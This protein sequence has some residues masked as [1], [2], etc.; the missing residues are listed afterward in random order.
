VT[1]IFPASRRSWQC[2]S[3]QSIV[4]GGLAFGTLDLLF[5]CTFWGALRDVA[6]DRILQSI[7]AGVQGKAAF[8]GGAGSAMLGARAARAARCWVPPA[9]ISSRR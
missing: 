8:E 7:A 5:A 6:P 1:T 9:T 3:W 4:L 2:R